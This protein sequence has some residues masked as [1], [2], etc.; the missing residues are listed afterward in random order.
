MKFEEKT[1]MVTQSFYNT[2]SKLVAFEETDWQILANESETIKTWAPDLV[3]VFYDTLYSI[4]ETTAVFHDG[5]RPKLEATLKNWIGEILGGDQGEKFWNHQ[6]YIALLHIKRGTKN[7]YMLGMMN[8]LQQV[9]LI[10]SL[11]SFDQDKAVQVYT[12]FL[13]LSGMV[14]GLI[15]QC[16]DEVTETSTQA[17]L[18]RVGLNEALISRIKAMQIDK[19]L[20]EAQ[21]A[22]KS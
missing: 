19:M 3:S 16:Y 8:R 2:I 10:K 12:A 6:R 1:M 17:G 18:S 21:E 9:F 13:R 4:E 22:Y 20:S 14:A 11:E 15:A 7:L 5:E